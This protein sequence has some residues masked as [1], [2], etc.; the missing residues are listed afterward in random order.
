M[1]SLIE[2]LERCRQA[3]TLEERMACVEQFLAVVAPTMRRVI[4]RRAPPL[5]FDDIVQKALAAVAAGLHRCQAQTDREAFAWCTTIA[6][7]KLADHWRE[8]KGPDTVS[9]DEKGV[10]RWLAD[11]AVRDAKAA[12]EIAAMEDSLR[13]WAAMD[14]ECYRYI[15]LH[16]V[17]CW[18]YAEIGQGEGLSEDA[19][20]M[21]V[22]RCLAKGREIL[23]QGG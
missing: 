8:P 4:Q 21:R 13:V 10:A 12:E 20:R 2:L 16:F 23:G 9:L 19:T 14:P 18:T 1:E 17:E 3:A 11:A 7:R 5:A 15:W 22:K 6:R